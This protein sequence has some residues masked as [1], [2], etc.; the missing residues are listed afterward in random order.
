MRGI[1]ISTLALA[2]AMSFGVVSSAHSDGLL[3]KRDQGVNPVIAATDAGSS[4]VPTGPTSLG[5]PKSAKAD[6]VVVSYYNN[7]SNLPKGFPTES[8][9]VKN[10]NGG[11][12]EADQVLHP[13]SGRRCQRQL[14]MGSDVPDR[15]LLAWHYPGVDCGRPAEAHHSGYPR[16]MLFARLLSHM[17]LHDQPRQ[18]EAGG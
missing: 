12:P 11:A 3:L 4:G 7:P 6:L 15:R 5:A 8:Y 2:A 13:Q 1:R 10:P 14:H 9:C 18:P 17:P 16:R